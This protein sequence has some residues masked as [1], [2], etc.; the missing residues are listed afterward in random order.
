MSAL[1]GRA[2]LVTGANRGVGRGIVLAAAAAG[3]CVAVTARSIADAEAV[4]EELA[5]RLVHPR[6][7]AIAVAC[8]VTIPDQIH[9]AVAAC[10]GA[11]GRLDALVHNAVS[12]RSAEPMD[13]ATADDDLWTEHAS[14]SITPLH[15]IAVATHD[16][17]AKSAG[18]LLILTSPAGING[19]AQLSFYGAVKGAQRGFVRSLAREWGPD[20]IRVNG[21]APL[22]ATPALENAFAEDP[23]MEDRLRRMIPMGRFG[24]PENDIGPAAVFLCSDAARYIT[25]QQMIVSGGRLTTS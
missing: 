1:T 8:D 13:L 9:A 18:S 23:T 10:V 3:A 4:I 7:N 21:L 19:T 6:G 17:L 12:V 2:V 22:A 20:G 25:G 11:F 14:V 5:G 24:D 16:R 15:T